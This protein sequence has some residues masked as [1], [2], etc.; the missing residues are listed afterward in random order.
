MYKITRNLIAVPISDFLIPLVRP[1]QHYHLLRR[2]LF[3]LTIW[4]AELKGA[5]RAAIQSDQTAVP[6]HVEDTG[7]GSVQR[8]HSEQSRSNQKWNGWLEFTEWAAQW[9]RESQYHKFNVVDGFNGKTAKL[10]SHTQWCDGNKPT[11]S[12]VKEEEV[13]TEVYQ[14]HRGTSSVVRSDY[15]LLLW[16]EPCIAWTVAAR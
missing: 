1:S 13:F 3:E 6:V 14:G 15:P 2:P 8:P 5:T 12:M 11:G 4:V 16:K 9:V 10:E 7:I